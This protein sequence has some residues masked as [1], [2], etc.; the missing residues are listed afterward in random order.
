MEEPKN[1]D[2]KREIRN[3]ERTVDGEENVGSER[4]SGGTMFETVDT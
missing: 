4:G 3:M 1:N 2:K